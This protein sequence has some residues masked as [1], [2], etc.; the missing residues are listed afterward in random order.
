MEKLYVIKIQLFYLLE[1][2]SAVGFWVALED[3]TLENGCL[4]VA[5]G[6]HKE[7][8]RKIIY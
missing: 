5:S 3:A 6:S 2:E 4:L 8:L 1:P 7:P